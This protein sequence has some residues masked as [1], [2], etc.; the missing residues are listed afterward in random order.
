MFVPTEEKNYVVFFSLFHG[1]EWNWIVTISVDVFDVVVEEEE[2]KFY[3]ICSQNIFSF[4]GVSLRVP[5]NVKN[6]FQ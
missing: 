1:F 6:G 3:L 4:Q 5:N 2:E